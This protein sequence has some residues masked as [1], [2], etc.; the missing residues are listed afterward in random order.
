IPANNGTTLTIGAVQE[1]ALNTVGVAV[2][3]TEGVGQTTIATLHATDIATLVSPGADSPVTIGLNTLLAG[4]PGSIDGT[5]TGLTQLG[6]SITWHVVSGTEIDGV[7]GANVVFTIVK[8]GSDFVFTLKDNIDSDA[9]NNLATGEGD[10]F[11]TNLSLA[12]VFTAT[13]TDGDKIIIDAGAIVTIENDIPANN[14]T[15]LT[16]G[17]VQEDALN[18]VGVAVGN[19][20]GVGQTTIATLHATDI[21]TLV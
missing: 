5:A 7:I 18:T 8:S 1:D 3:N 11:K 15:T 2:G 9:D 13:D 14:G 17:A 6:V 4:A 20:E 19:T 10:A 21:A 12:G 16:I